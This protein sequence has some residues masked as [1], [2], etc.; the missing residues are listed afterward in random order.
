[1]FTTGLCLA[2]GGHDCAKQQSLTYANNLGKWMSFTPQIESQHIEHYVGMYIYIYY[3]CIQLRIYI[4]IYLGFRKWGIPKSPWVSRRVF[5]VIHDDW[6]IWGTPM[7][8]ESS[9]NKS[10]PS[11]HTFY[12]WQRPSPNRRFIALGFPH[13]S[14][15]FI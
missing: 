10:S 2:K 8:L 5:M 9:T 11:H 12:G 14:P 1:M 15:T 4:Y 3:I 7:T 13:Y 6:M